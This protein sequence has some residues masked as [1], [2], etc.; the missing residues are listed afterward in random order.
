[1]PGAPNPDPKDR[2]LHVWQ[3]YK[4]RRESCLLL[5]LQALITAFTE[6]KDQAQALLDK[7]DT[8]VSTLCVMRRNIETEMANLSNHF[9]SWKVY[10]AKC[11][12][13]NLECLDSIDSEVEKVRLS[14]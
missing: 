4:V 3:S 1:M 13:R 5:T 10:S 9:D 2:Y 8:Q 6:K 7:M 11:R 12:P 14:M